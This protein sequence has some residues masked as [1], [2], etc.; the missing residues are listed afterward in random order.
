[1]HI[2][3]EDFVVIVKLSWLYD[4]D[5]LEE[6][7]KRFWNTNLKEIIEQE[8]FSELPKD[9]FQSMIAN[10]GEDIRDEEVLFSAIVKWCEVDNEK[11]NLFCILIGGDNK[12][13]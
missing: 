3:C 13:T 11:N 5:S 2:N 7:L 4:C 9:G 8:N 10:I 12:L 6:N 1:M